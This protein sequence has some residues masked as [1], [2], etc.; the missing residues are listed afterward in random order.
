MMKKNLKCLGLGGLLAMALLFAMNL[1]AQDSRVSTP[2]S[3]DLFDDLL[4]SCM[5]NVKR[6]CTVWARDGGGGEA[7]RGL[8]ADTKVELALGEKYV[9]TGQVLI[10]NG[11]PYLHIDFHAQPWLANRT[12]ITNPFYR[13]NDTAANWTKYAGRI[14]TIVGTARYRSWTMGGQTFL[15]IYVDPAPESVIGALQRY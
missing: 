8:N 12:R 15:E 13:I 9:L 2:N 5:T 11:N 4:D 6:D 10:Q 14:M 3:A 7:P 1:P